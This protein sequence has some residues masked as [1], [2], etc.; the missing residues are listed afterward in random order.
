MLLN[1]NWSIE[2]NPS[3]A[4]RNKLAR[5]QRCIA[6]APSGW[7]LKRLFSIVID[8]VVMITTSG[9]INIILLLLL[10]KD[11]LPRIESSQLACFS[12]GARGKLFDSLLFQRHE[13]II[14][15]GCVWW[16]A[17]LYTTYIVLHT[18][19]TSGSVPY[20]HRRLPIIVF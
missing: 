5:N 11:T 20:H 9:Q 12:S 4:D 3:D 19:T 17:K 1:C 6:R 13:H 8:G 10:L 7:C 16:A 15:W 14:M 2:E 18:I